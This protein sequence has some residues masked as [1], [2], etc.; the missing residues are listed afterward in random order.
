MRIDQTILVLCAVL[1]FSMDVRS[2][3]GAFNDSLQIK[4]YSLIYV[5]REL[6]VDSIGMD[7][8]FCDY[9]S[10]KQRD[11]VRRQAIS[12]T[13]KKYLN[14]LYDK[15]GVYRNVLYLRY[16]KEEFRKLNDQ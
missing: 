13:K 4:V 10:E 3:A 9:C 8:I 14:K 1:S 11:L 7:R 2:Q 5:N 12:L 16:R 6:K 15:A